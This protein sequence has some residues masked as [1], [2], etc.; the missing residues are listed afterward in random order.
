MVPLRVRLQHGKVAGYIQS[1]QSSI[2]RLIPYEHVPLGTIQRWLGVTALVDVLFS[3]RE[4]IPPNN[5]ECLEHIPFR[6]PPPEVRLFSCAD[7]VPSF[8][9]PLQFPVVFE[10]VF[11]TA[12]DTIELRSA[13]AIDEEVTK[14][15]Q[16]LVDDFES[17][18]TYLS[19]SPDDELSLPDVGNQPTFEWPVRRPW[20]QEEKPA[21][22]QIVETII[23]ELS[24]FLRIPAETVREGHSLLS[25]GLDSLKAVTLS[26]RLRGQ[27]ISIPPIDIIRAG[28]VREVASAS[29][30]ERDQETSSQ[31]ESGSELDQLLWQ[32]LPVESVR[33]GTDDRVEITAATALQ[34]GMLSQVIPT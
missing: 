31:E 29:V 27:G 26:H 20:T 17:C 10:I 13:V 25:L 14:T 34:A 3:V 30:R 24:A 28:S 22:P 6:P 5:Y 8:F 16:Q 23:S 21:D 15:V 33:L 12:S 9:T 4:E 32:D 7:C 19:G 11:N 1:C 2:T 18:V